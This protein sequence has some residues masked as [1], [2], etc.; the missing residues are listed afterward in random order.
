MMETVQMS[1]ECNVVMLSVL[2]EITGLPEQRDPAKPPEVACYR[3]IYDHQQ[4]QKRRAEI[5]ENCRQHCNTLGA[6]KRV[7]SW[8]I[9]VVFLSIYRRHSTV[10][11]G[12]TPNINVTQLHPRRG[13]TF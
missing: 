3:D 1:L 4:L 12:A 10:C 6:S 13:N 5:V 7:S 9:N 11:A 2:E 8:S